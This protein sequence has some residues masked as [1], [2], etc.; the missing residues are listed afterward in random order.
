MALGLGLH[1]EP[2]AVT[3]N[4]TLLYEQRRVVWWIIYCF[5]SGLSLTTGRPSTISNSFIETRFPRNIDDS[6]SE[7]HFC[8]KGQTVD[9]NVAVLLY[10]LA[11]PGTNGQNNYLFGHYCTSTFGNH[12]KY[13]LQ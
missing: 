6:V 3:G 12:R 7:N 2:S 13:G 5:D 11:S 9:L 4:D 1:R 8:S 10:E